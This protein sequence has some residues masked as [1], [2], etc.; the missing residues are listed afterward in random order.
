LEQTAPLPYDSAQNGEWGN[1]NT[2]LRPTVW[3]AP[4]SNGINGDPIDWNIVRTNHDITSGS[5]DITT[6][7]L[8]VQSGELEIMEP[9]TEDENN[10]GHMLWVTHYLSLDGVIDLVGESQ[11]IQKPYWSAQY[12]ESMLE[13]NSSGYIERD[14]QGTKNS[15]AYN[16]WSLPV[17]AIN[18]GSNNLPISPSSAL[19]D[20]STSS[21]PLNI[22]F[23]SPYAYAD[24]GGNPS[25][26]RLSSY[27]IY[28]FVNNW[29]AYANW[30]HVGDGGLLN[31]TEG[32]S[33]KG[34]DP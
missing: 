16:Y 22:N 29:N 23:G 26:I 10:S 2:W 17:S 11:L 7:G 21:N 19:R 9:G 3:D 30:A 31:I 6:L 20:G 32:F 33:M 4:N 13:P 12:Y 8:Y 15:Y 25:P 28:K 27:W 18:V 14:Q 1:V 34:T 5:K 24:G